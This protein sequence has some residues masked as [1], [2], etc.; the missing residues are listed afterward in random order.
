MENIFGSNLRRSRQKKELTQEQVASA[1]GVSYQAV[2]KWENGVANPDLSLIVPLAKL[3]EVSTD[4][5]LGVSDSAQEERKKQFIEQIRSISNWKAEGRKIQLEYAKAFVAE[6]PNDPDALFHYE[7]CLGSYISYDAS[8]EEKHELLLLQEQCCQKFLALPGTASHGKRAVTLSLINVLCALDRRA[9]AVKLA[10]AQIEDKE[11]QLDCLSKCLEGDEKTV[12]L[13]KNASEKAHAFLRALYKLE[14][15]EAYQ[16]AEDFLNLLDPIPNDGYY[17]NLITLH[18]MK[19]RR[20]VKLKAYDKVMEEYAV[21]ADLAVKMEKYIQAHPEEEPWYSN[22][23]FQ[24]CTS[25]KE[26]YQEVNPHDMIRV[27][28]TAPDKKAMFE[29]EDH[30]ELVKIVTAR[31]NAFDPFNKSSKK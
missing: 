9:E 3:L 26:L 13:L 16:T 29:R 31:A 19:A 20:Y 17:E 6:F 5:L 30:K 22:P 12:M 18:E 11:F 21:C 2:S 25:G 28:L 23:T 10:K 14:M 8:Q 4:E 24:K 15:D 27:F 7:N 1:L